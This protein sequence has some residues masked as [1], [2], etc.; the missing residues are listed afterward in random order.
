MK[1]SLKTQEEWFDRHENCSIPKALVDYGPKWRKSGS[2]SR[3]GVRDMRH[4]ELYNL[5]YVALNK[6]ARTQKGNEQ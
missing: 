1:P 5:N 3:F 4:V 6:A 2:T